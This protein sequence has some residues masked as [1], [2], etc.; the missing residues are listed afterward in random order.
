MHAISFI[1]RHDALCR[2]WR[3]KGLPHPPHDFELIPSRVK[4]H[5]FKDYVVNLIRCTYTDY[6]DNTGST[7][8]GSDR[9]DCGGLLHLPADERENKMDFIVR[10][11]LC[12][13]NIQNWL[14]TFM[15]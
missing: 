8:G 13:F 2:Y 15:E 5:P 4:I 12:L 6:F 7:C 9:W 3:L 10:L 14:I 1:K 11:V